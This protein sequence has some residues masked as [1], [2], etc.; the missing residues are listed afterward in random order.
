MKRT[1]HDITLV[2]RAGLQ[3]QSATSALLM[4]VLLFV[5]AG[6]I[7]YLISVAILLALVEWGNMEVN[8]AN[9]LA[10]LVAIY[11]AH[12][13]NGSF[14]FRQGKHAP[15]REI[16]MFFLL[17]FTGLL[18][19]MALMYLLTQYT[20][21]WYILSK[22]LVTGVVAIFNFTTRKFLVFNG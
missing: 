12:R 8:L 13:L 20:A 17:S 6:G 14:V 11:A 1:W 5:L 22:T 3:K 16:S 7:C 21:L 9:L 4:Q 2:M 15:A 19:N 10:S 18:L